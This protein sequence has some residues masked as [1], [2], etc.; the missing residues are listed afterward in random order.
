MF[1]G[2]ESE[3]KQLTEMYDSDHFE[4]A[5]IYGR[6]RI[7]KTTLINEFCKGKKAIYYMSSE[8]TR[9]IN[10]EG[11]SQA[12][13]DTLMPDVAMPAF[14]SFDK[15]LDFLDNYSSERIIL[16][17]DEY[18]YL[19]ESDRSI[20]SI[21]QSHIDRKW[22]DSKVMLILCGSSMSFMEYQVLGYKSPLYGR[23]TAQ[24]KLQPFT[25]FETQKFV[26]GYSL[27]E[28]AILYGVSGGVPEYLNRFSMERS[29]EENIVSL[30]FTRSGMLFEEPT[31]LLKQ[32]LRNFAI[33]NAVIKAIA[34]GASR[35]NEISMKVGEET[36]ACANQLNALIAL[37]LVRKEVP[38]TENETSR[39]TLYRIE[40]SMFRFWYRFV[41]PNISSIE[42]DMGA[43]VFSNKVLPQLNDFMGSVFEEICMEY[44]Y[45]PAVIGSAPF[46]YGNLGR[47]WGNNPKKKK[48]E[49]IDLLGIEGESILLGECKWNNELAGIPV[50]TTLIE[51]GD[52]FYQKD[53]W[54]YLFSKSGFTESVEEKAKECRNIRL[55]SLS[56]MGSF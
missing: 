22:K 51:R 53:K 37:G 52:L 13:F 34:T 4:F 10:L 20:S 17:I 5:V 19:A 7:G 16:A 42:R 56:D 25:Y 11:L 8:S 30:F 26:P 32:E 9:K 47:W 24:F 35:L 29:L 6:R 18:P 33:Y 44:M 21:L 45:L 40:D 41:S 15:L 46:F 43:L 54:F 1:I 23:R 3:L 55:I 38:C 49:E 2:R 28:Q 14:E 48:Q 50:L 12:V 31:N 36:A 39:K 27:E